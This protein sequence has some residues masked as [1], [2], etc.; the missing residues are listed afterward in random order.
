MFPIGPSNYKKSPLNE[1]DYSIW[2]LPC[3]DFLFSIQM[4]GFLKIRN[5]FSYDFLYVCRTKVDNTEFYLLVI[6]Y[7]MYLEIIS[8]CC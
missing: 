6:C 5:S 2:V 3:L 7:S 1:Y 4:M 8:I